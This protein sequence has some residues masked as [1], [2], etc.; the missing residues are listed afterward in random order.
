MYSK[1][2]AAEQVTE[3]AL[4]EI[5]AGD[6]SGVPSSVAKLFATEI[7][8]D[9]T[10]RAVQLCGANATTDALPLERYLRDARMLTIIG[11][12]SEIQKRTIARRLRS[13]LV[14]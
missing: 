13:I 4:R 11:G 5:A 1:C 7:A 2:R 9:V 3:W 8:V 6:E 14:R 12:T 10:N